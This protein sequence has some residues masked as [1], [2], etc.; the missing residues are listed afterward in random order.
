VDSMEKY[1]MKALH[2]EV[3]ATLPEDRHHDSALRARISDME[4][5]SAVNLDIPAGAVQD[6]V[7]Q[8]LVFLLILPPTFLSHSSG[9]VLTSC[10]W[11]CRSCCA[12]TNTS[13]RKTN[14]CV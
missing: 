11:R 14:S 7:L 10:S 2:K 1:I 12:S 9:L 6:T 13:H 5:V 4:F 3:F 8:V